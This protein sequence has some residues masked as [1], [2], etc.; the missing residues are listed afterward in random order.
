M[1][2]RKDLLLA[3]WVVGCLSI[4][5]SAGA[6]G[7]ATRKI[8]AA[9]TSISGAM[10]PPWAAHEAGIFRRYG[11]D[12]EVIAMPSGIQGM[13]ALIAGEVAFIHIAGG[14]TAGAAVSGADVKIVLPRWEPCC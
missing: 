13:G 12:V 5:T 6:A 4:S 10:V 8:R 2:R 1:Q 7:E 9:I 11:L 14:T 3:L